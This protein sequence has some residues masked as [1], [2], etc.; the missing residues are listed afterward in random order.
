MG[1]SIAGKAITEAVNDI[2][3][4]AGEDVIDEI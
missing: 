3:D 1:D 2:A 4:M